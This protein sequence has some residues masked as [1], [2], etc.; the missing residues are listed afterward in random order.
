MAAQEYTSVTSGR[1]SRGRMQKGPSK[2]TNLDAD[3]MPAQAITID[4]STAAAAAS[5]P[6]NEQLS[7]LRKCCGCKY[8]PSAERLEYDYSRDKAKNGAKPQPLPR[9]RQRGQYYIDSF[10]G[11]SWSCSFGTNEEVRFFVV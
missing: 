4:P 3:L 2:N 9:I 11:E 1:R 5:I 6:R 7:C 8:N 10:N